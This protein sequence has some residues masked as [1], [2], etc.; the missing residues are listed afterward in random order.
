MRWSGVPTTEEE[1]E[2]P[3]KLEQTFDDWICIKSLS[4]VGGSS[5]KKLGSLSLPEE[6][7]SGKNLW[8]HLR[9]KV[10]REKRLDGIFFSFG[11]EEEEEKGAA[12]I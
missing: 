5:V 1:E 12:V 8:R 9:R 11:W 4:L 7:L 6:S 2:L 3:F 10:Q